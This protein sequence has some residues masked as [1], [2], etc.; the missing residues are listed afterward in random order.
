MAVWGIGAYFLGEGGGDQSDEFIKNGI[1]VIGYSREEHPDYYELMENI[2][3]GDLIY[4]KSR[5]MN[6]YD[7]P[8]KLKAIG[9]VVNAEIKPKNLSVGTAQG[10]DVYWVNSFN[11][12][13]REPIK[14]Q[15]PPSPLYNNT[16]FEE[17]DKIVIKEIVSYLNN[18][19]ALK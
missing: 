6:K 7:A 5:Q 10:I 2:R 15:V 13:G 19:D 16:L 1:A 17:K 11:D 18:K 4:I 8:I 3:E 9:I 14:I 12:S